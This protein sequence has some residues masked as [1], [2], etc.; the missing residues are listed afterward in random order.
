M[1]FLTVEAMS[2]MTE[3]NMISELMDRIDE[4]AAPHLPEGTLME[5][6]NLMKQL[7]DRAD[8]RE[9][10]QSRRVER[11]E[12]PEEFRARLMANIERRGNHPDAVPNVADVARM[13]ENM[14]RI[15]E[16]PARQPEAP[17]RQARAARDRRPTRSLNYLVMADRT[18]LRANARGQL[19]DISAVWDAA[20]KRIITLAG[21]PYT[22]P[23]GW[24]TALGK[25][26]NGWEHVQTAAGIRL[27]RFYDG[28]NTATNN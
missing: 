5:V 2:R 14:G 3:K 18:Q 6:M 20:T 26:C 21:V 7:H 25:H 19:L 8:A 1:P 13:P 17:A 27:D 4:H 28:S 11:R 9:R 10:L 23:S 24:L 12:T 16:A 22:S 15:P